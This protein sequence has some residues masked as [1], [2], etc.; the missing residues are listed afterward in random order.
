L[1]HVFAAAIWGAACSL[2]LFVVDPR[3]PFSRLIGVAIVA[4]VA[5]AILSIG[6]PW[7]VARWR[8]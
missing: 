8:R 5:A 2:L 1:E 7:I 6:K 3:Q 4:A